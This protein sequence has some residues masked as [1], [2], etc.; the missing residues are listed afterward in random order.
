MRRRKLV[1]PVGDSFVLPDDRLNEDAEYVQEVITTGVSVVRLKREL[2]AEHAMDNRLK[3]IKKRNEDQVRMMTEEY[4]RVI[5]GLTKTTE[6]KDADVTRWKMEYSKLQQTLLE[7]TTKSLEEGRKAGRQELEEIMKAKLDEIQERKDEITRIRNAFEKQ[8]S[9]MKS[10]HETELKQRKE[11][12]EWLRK[13][14]EGKI[15]QI[16]FDVGDVK[17]IFKNRKGYSSD[18]IGDMG[19]NFVQ[20]YIEENY[21]PAPLIVR[22]PDRQKQRADMIF[23]HQGVAILIEVKFKQNLNEGDLRKFHLDIARHATEYPDSAAAI[24]V[25]L[26]EQPVING[27]RHSVE[28]RHGMP[29]LYCSGV[30]QTPLLLSLSIAHATKLAQSGVM[31][32]MTGSEDDD[33][34]TAMIH[35]RRTAVYYMALLRRMQE[36]I[37]KDKRISDDMANRIQ[38]RQKALNDFAIHQ[39]PLYETFPGIQEEVN[40]LDKCTVGGG[41]RVTHRKADEEGRRAIEEWARNQMKSFKE[42][43]LKSLGEHLGIDENKDVNSYVTSLLKRHGWSGIKKLKQEMGE[44]C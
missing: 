1:L 17:N 34:E 7:L 39:T 31:K 5:S 27:Q 21:D 16:Q 15:D 30:K 32:G 11:E 25:C 23:T 24:M 36:D 13:C 6:E 18:E 44:C 14:N 43:S 38:A 12:I 41:K 20:H 22:D 8:I 37:D 29:V 26:E 10:A 28:A 40:Q 9:D 42:I 4:E 19:E 3:E 35:H 2:E 33:Y